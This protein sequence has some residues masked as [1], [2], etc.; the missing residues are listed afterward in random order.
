MAIDEDEHTGIPVAEVAVAI[1]LQLVAVMER[2]GGA[3]GAT[4]PERE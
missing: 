1:E 2:D 3:L 4:V